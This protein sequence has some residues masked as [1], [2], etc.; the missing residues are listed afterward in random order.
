ME[1]RACIIMTSETIEEKIHRARALT[2]G[3]KAYLNAI[4]MLHVVDELR[5][6]AMLSRK[7]MQESGISDICRTCAVTGNGSGCCS[8]E[9]EEWYE[10]PTLILNRLMGKELPETPFRED[11]CIF[12]GENGCRLL[13]RH[14]FCLNYLCRK[15]EAS[16]PGECI[17]MVRVAYGH[18]IFAAWELEREIWRYFNLNS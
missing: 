12:L 4:G 3:I 18:E 2:P 10:V 14:H 9:I 7:I 13:V 16:I 15:I 8:R 17:K 5:E 1:T 11:T 6:K